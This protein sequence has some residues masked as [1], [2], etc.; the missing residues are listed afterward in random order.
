MHHRTAPALFRA[1]AAFLLD[2]AAFRLRRAAGRALHGLRR[3]NRSETYNGCCG[4][5]RYQCLL[6]F[7]F[8]SPVVPLS[9]DPLHKP[10]EK[11][12]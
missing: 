9:I 3:S 1:R 12:F 6:H 2:L 10:H 7:H 4:D 11:E 8:A 5:C